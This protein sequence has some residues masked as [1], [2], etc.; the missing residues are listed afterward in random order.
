[1]LSEDDALFARVRDAKSGRGCLP[2]TLAAL[3]DEVSARF[4][5][6][7]LHVAYD[8]IEIGP[9]VG[10]PRL[11]LIVETDSD[12]A[13]LRENRFKI[14]P[15][16]RRHVLT[17]LARLAAEREPGRYETE[18]VLLI[19]DC[20]ADVC[21]ERACAEFRQRDAD[22]VIEEFAAARIWRIDGFARANVVFLPTER[23][24]GNARANGTADRIAA[25][26]LELIRG[27]DEFGYLSEAD[28]EVRLDSKENLDRHY[29]GNLYSYFK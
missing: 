23:E 25:R 11:N 20:F 13:T 2:P 6:Q 29:R 17:R 16:V 1:M 28:V 21:L 14:R 26:C 9:S 8:A 27:Y 12:H 24:V 10:R 3:R 15:D 22:R 19:T 4:S 18:N 5:V 7:V